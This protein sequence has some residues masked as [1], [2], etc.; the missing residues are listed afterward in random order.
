M[1]AGQLVAHLIQVAISNK[2]VESVIKTAPGS[3]FDPETVKEQYEVVSR[4]P[5]IPPIEPPKEVVIPRSPFEYISH[6]SSS[7]AT[8]DPEFSCVAFDGIESHMPSPENL[9][10]IDRLVCSYHARLFFAIDRVVSQWLSKL[11]MTMISNLQR[12]QWIY[13]HGDSFTYSFLTPRNNAC[14]EALSCLALFLVHGTVTPPGCYHVWLDESGPCIVDRVVLG[15]VEQRPLARQYFVS[16]LLPINLERDKQSV[17]VYFSANIPKGVCIAPLVLRIKR[18]T[19]PC[20]SGSNN[21]EETRKTT[22][23]I[24]RLRQRSR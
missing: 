3:V 4:F 13:P 11:D 10:C 5:S 15:D 12:S 24:P 21:W 22:S 1:T 20:L 9:Y 19:T 23:D 7:Y 2:P 8:I 6:T 14:D 16:T 18:S 17:R